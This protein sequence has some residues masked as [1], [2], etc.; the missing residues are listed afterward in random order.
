MLCEVLMQTVYYNKYSS[1]ILFQI[2]GN[3][4]D[5]KPIALSLLVALVV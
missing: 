5:P 1:T 2:Y 4:S 3:I